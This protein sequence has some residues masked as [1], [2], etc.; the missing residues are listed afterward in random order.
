[1]KS[2]LFTAFLVGLAVAFMSISCQPSTI[3]ISV[4]LTEAVAVSPRQIEFDAKGGSVTVAINA[5]VNWAIDCSSSWVTSSI[6][7]GTPN[8][9]QFTVS[10]QANTDSSPRTSTIIVKSSDCEGTI[11]IAVSQK[12]A[13][14]VENQLAKLFGNYSITDALDYWGE[15]HSWGINISESTGDSKVSLEFFYNGCYITGTVNLSERTITLPKHF[16]LWND[17]S[18]Q[19]DFYSIKSVS[20]DKITFDSTTTI[21]FDSN[22][23]KIILPPFGIYVTDKLGSNNGWETIYTNKLSF[24]KE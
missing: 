19:D 9:T 3:S 22:F 23:S 17:N 8:D 6:L 24:L 18:S 2:S 12:A 10:A 11:E 15:K 7:M 14:P 16:E 21:T 5:T 20:G 4:P 13:E 1:M